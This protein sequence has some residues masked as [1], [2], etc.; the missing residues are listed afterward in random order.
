LI[1]KEMDKIFKDKDKTKKL[2]SYII[3]DITIYSRPKTE[4]D[5]IA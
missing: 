1:E 4:L 2:L 3:E 5:I